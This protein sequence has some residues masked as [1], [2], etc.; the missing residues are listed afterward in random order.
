MGNVSLEAGVRQ[1]G[2]VTLV[3]QDRTVQ[4]GFG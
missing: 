2:T 1:L 3:V 4:L